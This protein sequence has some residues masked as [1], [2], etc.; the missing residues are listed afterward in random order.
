MVVKKLSILISHVLCRDIMIEIILSI[1]INI[2]VS[3]IS[4]IML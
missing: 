3:V 1:I 4:I 2:V